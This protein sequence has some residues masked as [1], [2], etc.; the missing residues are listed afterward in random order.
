MQEIGGYASK[1]EICNLRFE[2]SAGNLG[3]FA[4]E[5]RRARRFGTEDK[6]FQTA[7][8]EISEEAFNQSDLKRLL[9]KVKS[10][11]SSGTEDN[12]C[13]RRVT[14]LFNVRSSLP[15]LSFVQTAEGLLPVG[16]KSVSEL[17][18]LGA[19]F[20]LIRTIESPTFVA[21]PPWTP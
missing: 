5:A 3:L 4:T 20:R 7:N 18:E 1:F 19:P 2:S 8:D 14:G 9:T 16:S 12:P 21:L 11:H 15:W 17:F 13:E 10:S 6:A